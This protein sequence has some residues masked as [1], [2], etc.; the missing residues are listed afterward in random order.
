VARI[1]REFRRENAGYIATTTPARRGGVARRNRGGATLVQGTINGYGSA[2]GNCQPTTILPNLFL[3]MDRAAYCRPN[4]RT[5]ECPI[6]WTNSQ[7]A[8]L[9]RKNRLWAPP[10]LPQGR[11]ARQCRQKVARSY[12]HIDPATVGNR[13]PCWCPTWR[14]RAA[15]S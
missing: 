6:T 9:V 2:P 12:E 13:T 8:A 5:S 1:V 7:S 15:S 3:K 4:L 10:R 14:G 11:A